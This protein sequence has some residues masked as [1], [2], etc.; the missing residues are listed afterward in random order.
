MKL[1]GTGHGSPVV[2]GDRIYLL[3]GDEQGGERI[4]TCLDAHTGEILWQREIAFGNSKKHKFNSVASTTAAVDASGVVFTWGT[5]E[6]LVVAAF[7]HDGDSVWE[8]THGSVKGGH[9]FGASP[10][11]FGDLV[12]L[13]NDQDKGEGSL[14]AL[15]RKSGELAWETT[16]N[17]QRLSY[18]TPVVYRGP[19]SDRDLLVF[20]NWQ[21]GFSAIDPLTGEVVAEKSVFDTSTNERAISSPIV[22]GDLVIGTCGFTNNP[23]HCVAMRLGP[24]GFE[25]VWRI[26]KSVAHIPS[27]VAVDDLVFM[28]GDGGI[29]TC[30]ERDTGA[31]VWRE[32]VGGATW[33]SSPVC[34]GD[35]LWNVDSDGRAV[36][37]K[38]GR[39]FEVVAE[40]GLDELTRATPAIAHGRLYVRTFESLLAVGKG[41]E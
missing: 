30:I 36:A 31:E 35:H 34:C 17:G 37:I 40:N 2:W 4:P 12:I 6:E 24:D 33:F 5:K 10:V 21:H 19:G 32:R 38:A 22:S 13:N 3:C 14:F 20:T 18:S 26:E 27:L 23:K 39:E 15:H 29:V 28:W 25:E 7:S 16:R 1:P 9:G 11:I 41:S 8:H